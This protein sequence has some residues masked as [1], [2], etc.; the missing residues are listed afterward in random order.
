MPMGNASASTTTGIAS[1]STTIAVT[2]TFAGNA[3]TCH[4]QHQH[5]HMHTCACEASVATRSSALYVCKPLSHCHVVVT[6]CEN[7]PRWQAHLLITCGQVNPAFLR[8]SSAAASSSFSDPP[9]LPPLRAPPSCASSSLPSAFGRMA[10]HRACLFSCPIV[11]A[12]ASGT[13]ANY[14]YGLACF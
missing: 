7:P 2:S 9:R 4:W 6:H 12:L 13:F 5:L 1:T 14:A 10:S 11:L 8:L 3:S